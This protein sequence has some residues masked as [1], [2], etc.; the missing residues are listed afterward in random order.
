MNASFGSRLKAARVMAGLSMD[1]LVA[2]MQKKISKQAISKYENGMMSPES[3][4]LIA[5]ARA[6]DVSPDY[7]FAGRAVELS[8]LNFRKKA[9]LGKRAVAELTERVRDSLERYIELQDIT[10]VGNQYVNPLEG[11]CISIETDLEGAAV[12]LRKKWGM[13]RSAPVANVVGLLEDHGVK[14]VEIA[15]YDGFDGLSGWADE[16]PFLVLSAESSTDR[17]R[18]TGLHEFAHLA[19]EFETVNAPALRE[20]YCHGFA[21]AVLLPAEVLSKELGKKRNELSLFELDSI[22]QEYGISMQAII[23]RASRLDI[24]S[25]Y[26][27]KQLTIEFSRRGWRKKEPNPLGTEEHPFHF[28]TLIHRALAEELITVSKAAYLAKKSIDEIRREITLG[29]ESH[30][31]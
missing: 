24:I 18:L 6:L 9:A 8:G 7:L 15:G 31:S 14:I 21:A 26:L 10:N 1:Q 12:L 3:R 29:D 16:H 20:K 17:K 23:H 13:G 19:L 11:T 4:I 28:E 25:P 30:S 5:L 22:K 2:K 27:L